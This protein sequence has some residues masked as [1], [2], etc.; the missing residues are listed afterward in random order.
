M[1]K[2]RK[3]FQHEARKKEGDEQ[4]KQIVMYELHADNN[5]SFSFVPHLLTYFN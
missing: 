1:K 5:L 3:Q 2:K 4:N